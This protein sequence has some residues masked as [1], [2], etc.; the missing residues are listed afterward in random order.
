MT[1]SRRSLLSLFT[2]VVSLSL[3]GFIVSKFPLHKL[4]ETFSLI[5]VQWIIPIIIILFGMTIA[6]I[7]RWILMA[8]ILIP[9]ITKIHLVINIFIGMIFSQTLPVGGDAARIVHL[10]SHKAP[11]SNTLVTLLFDRAFAFAALFSIAVSAFLLEI[12]LYPQSPI[13]TSFSHLSTPI[14]FTFIASITTS[15][16]LII[17]SHHLFPLFS[18]HKNP[19]SKLLYQTFFGLH[20]FSKHPLLVFL[21]FLCALV[22]QILACSIPLTVI[23]FAGWNLQPL[24]L[25]TA[26]AT[27]LVIAYLP[28]SVAGWG[29]RETGF[30]LI[31]PY[32]GTSEPQ[33]L[34]IALIL[35]AA[36]LLQGLVCGALVSPLN[37]YSLSKNQSP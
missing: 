12:L 20:I 11:L 28:I 37:L 15:L 31:A 29:V 9:H 14:I 8:S 18:Q 17:F 1:L 10:T 34:V 2:F 25:L 19:I 35:G 26:V 13:A 32:I 22:V 3:V 30:V 6:H 36:Q 7:T 16:L 5:G 4:M 21:C 23:F 27:I 33:A 24:S